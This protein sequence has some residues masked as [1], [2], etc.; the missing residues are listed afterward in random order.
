MSRTFASGVIIVSRVR[1]IFHYPLAYNYLVD[2]DRSNVKIFIIS[3]FINARNRMFEKRDIYKVM[4][5]RP[6]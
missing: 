1:H 5:D 4:V 6:E 3:S 2:L